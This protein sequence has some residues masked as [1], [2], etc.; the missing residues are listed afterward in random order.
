MSFLSTYK[1]PQPR[2]YSEGAFYVEDTSETSPDYFNVEYFPL[3]MGGGRH[4]IKLKGN[5]LNMK[6]NSTIDVEIIDADGERVYC[7][8]VDYYD[9]FNNYYISVDIYDIT[10]RGI[11]TAYFVGEA[12]YD[13]NGNPIPAEYVGGYNVR[14]TKQ[15]SVLPFERNNADLIFDTPPQ[16]YVA[17]IVAPAQS[18]TS[19]LTTLYAT[20]TSSATNLTIQS[21]NF[22]GYDRD[23]ASSTDILDPRLK[24]IKVDPNHQPMTENTVPTA[25]RQKDRD[26]ANGYL[27]NT[28]T[29]FGTIVSSSTPFFFKDMLGGYFEFFSNT[30]TPTTLL[31]SLPT[32]L[33][34]SGSLSSQLETYNATIVEV[35]NSRQAVIDKPVEVIVFD[36]NSKSQNSQ[37][38]YQYRTATRFTGSV[39]YAPTIDSYVTSSVVSSS[40]VEFTFTDLNPISGQVYRIKTST[41]LGSVVGEYKLL[42]DQIIKPVEYLTD[43]QYPNSLNYARHESDYKLLGHFYTQ[44]IVDDYWSLYLETPTS[45]DLVGGSRDAVVLSDSV[46]LSALYTQ[47]LSIT[48]TYNQ[49]YNKNQIYTLK[50][51]VVLD[52]YSELEVYMSSDQLNTYVTTTTA[53]PKAF[54]K[55]LNTERDRYSDEHS[56]FGKFVGKISND[57]P[58]RKTYGTVVMDFQ[59]DGDGLGK[60]LF[61]VKPIDYANISASAWISEMGIKPY[62]IN[63]FTPNIVQYAVPL[64][65]ELINA[66]QL[67]QSIDFKIEYFDYTGKQSEYTTY[68]DDLTLNLKQTIAT[69]TCQDQKCYFY[70]STTFANNY[71]NKPKY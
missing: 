14:W 63:G 24:A 49:N 39:I 6:L 38:K 33:T 17:Q 29:R 54:N 15:F 8:V 61:R 26:I 56:R 64:S 32:N 16:I 2:G 3:V 12:V 50:Y 22:Q 45:F 23:F 47:S 71:Q 7:E 59:T 36:S 9:R 66:T 51:N 40:Y 13:Q 48:T 65:Q 19:S 68:I 10:A 34:I 31:P 46:K 41:K 53:Y 11:A 20:V 37:T 55:S 42:N 5:G 62:L 35:V 4:V 69:N 1:I 44:S 57:L 27:L 28:T 43:A 60:P 52:P 70:Y 18:P 58:V 67:S 25:I 21:S 30:T